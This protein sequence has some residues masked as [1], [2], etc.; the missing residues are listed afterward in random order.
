MGPHEFV[1]ALCPN[2]ILALEAFPSPRFISDAFALPAFQGGLLITYL[3]FIFNQDLVLG[4]AAIALYP[5]QMYL[6]P[7]LQ[8]RVNELSK[9]RV[10]AVRTLA[11]GVGESVSG[12]AEIHANDTSRFER[13]RAGDRLGRI[14][15]IRYDIYRKKFFIKFSACPLARSPSI[16]WS[17]HPSLQAA[18]DTVVAMLGNYWQGSPEDVE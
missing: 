4:L 11:D 10:R 6:I 12:V 18:W 17:T 16:S 2:A 14:Y 9:Q 13:A 3:F 1:P 15:R 5:P 8:K 7:K